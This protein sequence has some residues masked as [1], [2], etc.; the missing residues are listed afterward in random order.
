MANP[1]PSRFN[2]AEAMFQFILAVFHQQPFKLP[3]NL[4]KSPR[5]PSQK[6]DSSSHFLFQ[7]QQFPEIFVPC[8]QYAICLPTGTQQILIPGSCHPDFP[9]RDYIMPPLSQGI[10]GY[11]VNILVGK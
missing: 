2:N 11:P 9:N 5:S 8:Y 10:Y 4:S 7:K 1:M 6:N 3:M